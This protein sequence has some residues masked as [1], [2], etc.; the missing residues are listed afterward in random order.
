MQCSYC[1]R[2]KTHS[3]MT[4]KTLIKACELAFSKGN[5]AGLGFFGGEPLLKKELIIK[6]IEYCK[7]KE[8]ETG[9][10]FSCK[11]TTNGTLL[12]NSFI[13]YAK[14]AGLEI[15]ISYDGTAQDICRKFCDGSNSGVVME[16]KAKLLLSYMP[17]SYALMTLA[18]SAIGE[19][20]KSIKHLYG[21]G[22]RKISMTPAYGKNV[23]WNDSDIKK[24]EKE[25]RK[26]ADFYS[27]T[28]KE[29]A[30]FFFSPFDSKISSLTKGT[31]PKDHCQ[32]GIRQL[33][34]TADGRLY[35]C[36]QFIGKE[37]F[38]LGTLESG[39][40]IKKQQ[41][42]TLIDNTP[43][44]C[45]NC[46]LKDRCTNSCGCANILET[47]EM[48]KISPLQCT[49]ERML[50]KICD[51]MAEKLFKDYPEQFTKRYT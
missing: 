40:D 35:P 6:A 16:E 33:T 13:S 4:E 8:K 34:V 25:L 30:R 23:N 17:N 10:K 9:K 44:D 14:A 12:D 39:I 42:L 47:G 31:S 18:P 26:I 41:A 2:E 29:G 51:K 36:T 1:T 7:N 11:I 5:S 24:L 3:D 28:F 20:Y 49:Y 32:L 19:L 48:N 50:I 22:F 15:A 21:I 27:D 43:E 45:K 37:A 46:D 38:C